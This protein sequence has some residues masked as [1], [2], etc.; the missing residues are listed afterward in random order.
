MKMS[1]M[2]VTPKK[3]LAH[4]HKEQDN[5]KVV[6]KLSFNALAWIGVTPKIRL[7]TNTTKITTQGFM[8]TLACLDPRLD[9]N[10]CKIKKVVSNKHDQE[11]TTLKICSQTKIMKKRAQGLIE[12]DPKTIDRHNEEEG[13]GV[14]RNLPL[15]LWLWCLGVISKICFQTNTTKQEEDF[16][17]NGCNTQKMFIN[18]HDK[19]DTRLI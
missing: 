5:M 11:W 1:A 3:W 18:K 9:S 17:S 16:D 12:Y 2:S 10:G 15:I 8:E 14:D 6:W 19:E 7:Q 13:I 4:K